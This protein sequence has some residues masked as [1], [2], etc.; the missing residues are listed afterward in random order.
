MVFKLGSIEVAWEP[1]TGVPRLWPE[2]TPLECLLEMQM[3]EFQPDLLHQHLKAC[4]AGVRIL[5]KFL[6][7]M[8]MNVRFKDRR[9][10]RLYV[11]GFEVR[12]CLTVNHRG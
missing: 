5:K 7:V 4:G 11:L 8:W 2:P 12:F 9:A 6:K 3:H 10:G 1:G